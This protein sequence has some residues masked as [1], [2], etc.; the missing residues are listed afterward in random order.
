MHVSLHCYHGFQNPNCLW[1]ITADSSSLSLKSVSRCSR[2][3]DYQLITLFPAEVVMAHL[4]PAFRFSRSKK[5]ILW[6]FGN[7]SSPTIRAASS[8]KP[9][10]PLIVEKITAAHV[11]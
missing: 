4:I 5:E 7:V 9:V 11:A 3:G 10:M 6:R 1:Q 2:C 8:V